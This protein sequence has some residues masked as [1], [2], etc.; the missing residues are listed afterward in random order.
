M[1]KIYL[2][3]FAMLISFNAHAFIISPHVGLDYVSSTPNGFGD[4]DNLNGISLNAGVKALGFLSV[5]GFYQKYKSQNA[6]DGTNSKPQSY[7]IDL[8]TDTLN[9]GIVEVLTSVGYAK[10]TLDGGKINH[11]MKNFEGSAYRLGFGG[12]VNLTDN[13]GIRAMYRYVLPDSN[14]L[15]KNIQELTIGLRYYFF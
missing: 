8:V 13:I 3:L 2:T 10:Y 1:K 9:L 7:G 15:K 4:I 11:R 6:L 5:E 12:Q 14:F